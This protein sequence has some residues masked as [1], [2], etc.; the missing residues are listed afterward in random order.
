MDEDFISSRCAMFVTTLDGVISVVGG[1]VTEKGEDGSC[2]SHPKHDIHQLLEN[3]INP[4]LKH[5][6]IQTVRRVRG[7]MG[8]PFYACTRLR[9]DPDRVALMA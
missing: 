2:E 4:D 8:N 5:N 6:W 9:Y 1:H 7:L 3:S